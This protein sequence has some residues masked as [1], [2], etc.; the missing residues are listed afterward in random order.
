MSLSEGADPT[1]TVLTPPAEEK[2]SAE[3]RL[4]C[5]VFSDVEQDYYITWSVNETQNSGNYEDTTFTRQKTKNGYL[6]TSVYTTTKNE[7]NGGKVFNCNVWP[8]GSG[9]AMKPHGVSK[10]SGNSLEC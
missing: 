8:A 3:V 5:L 10:A 4:A 6:V 9:E 2:D 1:V 7:W